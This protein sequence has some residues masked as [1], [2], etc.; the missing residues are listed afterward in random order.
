MQVFNFNIGIALLGIYACCYI[1][2]DEINSYFLLLLQLQSGTAPHIFSKCVSFLE[3][4]DIQLSKMVGF[5]SDGA[6]TMIG[7]R[8]RVAALFKKEVGWFL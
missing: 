3:D 4:L 2:E 6:S 5:G 8:G 1:V 7:T